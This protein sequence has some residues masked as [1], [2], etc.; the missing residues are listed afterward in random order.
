MLVDRP[1]AR[2]M[3][4]VRALVWAAGVLG[5]GL[6][7]LVV[8]QV[9]AEPAGADTP[10]LV[11]GV[12]DAVDT[13]D[14]ASDPVRA[15]LAAPAKL[16]VRAEAPEPEAPDL[17]PDASGPASGLVSAAA[18][19]VAPVV[20]ALAPVGEPLAPAVG[21]TTP[22]VEALA[23]AAEPLA[24]AV[25]ATAPIVDVAGATAG[26]VIDTVAPV[27]A[28]AVEATA[29]VVAPVVEAAGPIVAPLTDAVTPAVGLVVEAVVPVVAPV[30]HVLP[31]VVEVVDSAVAPV[32]GAIGPIVA[33]VAGSGPDPPAAGSRPPRSSPGAVR[34]AE[35]AS[36]D[37]P[38]PPAAIPW[39]VVGTLD[40]AP[41]PALRSGGG[42]AGAGAPAGGAPPGP[43]PLPVA[44]AALGGLGG[45]GSG[46]D[47]SSI[48]L[49]IL[50]GGPL[51][52]SLA[53]GGVVHDRA[54]RLAGLAGGPGCLPG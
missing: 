24:P 36:V 33:S 32:T 31:P 48:S 40:R 10:G 5:L 2:A 30:V 18:E 8:Q 3:R 37:R 28:P 21:A 4:P 47:G 20:E 43:L 50:A 46:G 53:R 41:I 51:G 23:P 27:L 12:V 52:L 49:A 44:S 45:S 9:L 11:E 1:T 35:G 54:A 34:R 38:A 13:V 7:V 19:P 15:A 17:V 26:A 42:T 14:G 29:L 25:E 6:I 39:R 22:V 16:P